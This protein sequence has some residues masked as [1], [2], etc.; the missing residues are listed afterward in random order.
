MRLI[1]LTQYY[2]PE[3]GA[4]QNRLS[5]MARQFKES[6]FEVHVLTAKPNYP[7]GVIHDDYKHGLINRKKEAGI[8]TIHCW[9]FVTRS[10][11][12]ILRLINYF[13]FVFSSA[14]IGTFLLP[15]ADLLIM[16]SPPLFLSISAWWLSRIKRA[17]LILNVSDL[18]PETAI[19]LGMLSNKF[20]K[21]IFFLFEAWSY[22]I[23]ALVT[24]QTQGIIISIQQRFPSKLTFLLTNGFDI[25]QFHLDPKLRENKHE[26]II[27]YAGVLGYAQNLGILLE[28]AKSLEKFDNIKFRLYGD[29]PM[30]DFLMEQIHSQDLNNI[31]ILG[32][33]PHSEIIRIMQ[34]WDIGLVPLA[35]TPLMAGAR[36]SKM[37][38]IMGFG[39]PVVLISPEGEASKIIQEAKAG[40]WVDANHPE[41]LSEKIHELYEN[42]KLSSE[43]GNNGREYVSR[44]FD[45]KKIFSDFFSFLNNERI[46]KKL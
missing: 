35:N 22:K 18:Y 41:C 38:E 10:K 5:N 3:T 13:S 16:E 46:I 11:N 34:F 45:R 1:I 31:E 42:S 29:G 21:K 39:L 4:P 17:K 37:F 27:G 24:G 20:L 8:D 32:H 44:Y 2:P 33:F 28:T 36:P 30:S 12:L 6:G 25:D 40:I 26:F 9:L 7:R 19:A 14:L 43:Y 23:S 15:K